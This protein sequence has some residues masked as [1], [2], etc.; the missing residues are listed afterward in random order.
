MMDRGGEELKL[1][2]GFKRRQK[3]SGR[4]CKHFPG[5]KVALIKISV[6]SFASFICQRVCDE[7]Q[8]LITRANN[9]EA[10]LDFRDKIKPY[11]KKRY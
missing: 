6:Q 2:T 5:A 9:V 4:T 7:V 10:F 3:A 11:L 8:P 1:R